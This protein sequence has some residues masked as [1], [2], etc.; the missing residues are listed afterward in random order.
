MY[1]IRPEEEGTRSRKE[2]LD[3]IID[4]EED[5]HC[6]QFLQPLSSGKNNMEGSR[7]DTSGEKELTTKKVGGELKE[8]LLRS[9]Q[10]E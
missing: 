7:T 6:D 8:Y 3:R 10:V 2:N 4:S 9:G 5:K 1:D